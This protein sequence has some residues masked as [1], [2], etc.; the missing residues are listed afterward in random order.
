MTSYTSFGIDGN[1]KRDYT[2]ERKQ[3]KKS[4]YYYCVHS[5][6]SLKEDAWR[7]SDGI[8]KRDLNRRDVQSCTAGEIP[9][10][11]DGNPKKKEKAL[12]AKEKRSEEAYRKN[13]ETSFFQKR[14]VTASKI[15]KNA[16][17]WAVCSRNYTTGTK[18]VGKK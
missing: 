13:D 4:Y 17:Y 14:N 10:I 18:K 2:S 15:S 7:K 3:S 11:S 16:S 12:K 5:A 9:C 8:G 6:R 1:K